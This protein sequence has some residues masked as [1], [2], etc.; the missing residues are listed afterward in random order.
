MAST[1]FSR[2]D[3]NSKEHARAEIADIQ[4]IIKEMR[5]E[6][7]KPITV[8]PVHT[9][10]H[11]AKVISKDTCVMKIGDVNDENEATTTH[12]GSKKDKANV[13]TI[14]VHDIVPLIGLNVQLKQV[15]GDACMIVDRDQH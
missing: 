9:V 10:Q 12:T 6:L 15:H 2:L 5:A 8:F 7:K 3:E 1:W 14:S 4:K 13:G 11:S